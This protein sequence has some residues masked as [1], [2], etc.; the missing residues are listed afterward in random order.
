MNKRKEYKNISTKQLMIAVFIFVVIII[1]AYIVGKINFNLNSMQNN[2][3]SIFGNTTYSSVRD[4]PDYS[5]EICVMINNNKPY[6]NEDDYTTEVFEKYS[7]LDYLG[8]CGV[9]YV[10]VCK[11]IMPP[12]GDKRGDISSVHPAGWNQTKINGEYL[13]NRCH[14]IAHSFS[15]EDA[16]KQNL[17][18]GTSYFNNHGMLPIESLLLEYM[19]KNEGNHVLYRVTPI[20]YGENL[21]ASGVEMEAYS[22]EDN[23]KL[24]FNVFVY[25]IQPGV[26]LNYATGEVLNN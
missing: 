4:I 8:R 5:G 21:L 20:F 2:N 23:G 12:D 18:T 3:T 7:D 11:E 25:N 10:N 17:I 14:L 1:L 6:F 9:A 22:V 13:Y 26:T 24:S 19:N 16:N 15:D